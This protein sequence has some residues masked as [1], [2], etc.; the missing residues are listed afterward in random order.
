MQFPW[1]KA[2]AGKELVPIERGRLQCARAALVNTVNSA[3]EEA[4]GNQAP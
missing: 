4:T 3:A 2:A 1:Q